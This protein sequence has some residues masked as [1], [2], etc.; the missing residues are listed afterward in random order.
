MKSSSYNTPSEDEDEVN[1]EDD[2]E[3]PV[4]D[5]E[6]GSCFTLEFEYTPQYPDEAPLMELTEP[7]NLLDEDFTPLKELLQE[8]V[9]LG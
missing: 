2:D 7:R 3:D 8:Q 6:E 9:R 4:I 1:T 5:P